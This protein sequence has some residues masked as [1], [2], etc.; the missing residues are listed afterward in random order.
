VRPAAIRIPKIGAESSLKAYGLT[1]TGELAV[2]PVTEPLQAGYY[3]GA[4]PAFDGDEILPGSVGSA[5]VM[6][7]VD[8]VINGQKG[9]P[10]LFYRLREL[11]PGDEIFIDRV[12]GSQLRFVVERVEQHDKDAFPVSDFYERA[13]RPRLNL[14]T[15]A[16][17][18]QRDERSY[19]DNFLVWS[20]LAP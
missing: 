7:H 11:V 14:A 3:G 18:F 12:D 19:R 10:G 2:P 15:C 1:E 16:G 20:V 8:G 9:R 4:D 6:A 5:I 17:P 13:D